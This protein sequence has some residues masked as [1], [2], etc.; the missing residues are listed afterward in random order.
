MQRSWIDKTFDVYQ[1]SEKTLKNARWLGLSHTC[2]W[3]KMYNHSFVKEHNC[4]FEEIAIGNDAWFV[5]FA[6]T[7]AEK[8]EVVNDYL[9]N[10][11]ILS[12]GITKGKRPLSQHIDVIVSDKKRNKLKVKA[13]CYDLLF[14]PGFN[15]EVVIRD[16]GKKTYW[17]L[18]M[19]RV[20]TEP[21]FDLALIL[22]IFRKLHILKDFK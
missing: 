9:Y 15:K 21:Y 4:R 22:V 3:N 11:M 13:G 5:N 6:G 10:Y 16:F 7:E 8:I 19:K 2:P 20:F 17:H 12:N 18:F 14:V 1:H